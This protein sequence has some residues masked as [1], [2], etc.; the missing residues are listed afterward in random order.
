MTDLSRHVGDMG[1]IVSKGG[2]AEYDQTD[3]LGLITLT[4]HTS[5]IGRSVVVHSDPDDLGKGT[6]P[7]SKTTGHAGGR[8][9]NNN[10]TTT[11]IFL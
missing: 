8:K 3:E 11:H 7:D 4:G 1:N 2:V 5:V 10:H 9:S 6:F